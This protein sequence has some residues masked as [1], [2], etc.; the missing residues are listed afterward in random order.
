MHRFSGLL[1]LLP[2]FFDR[3]I[4]ASKTVLKMA[5]FVQIQNGGAYASVAPP[6]LAVLP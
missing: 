2:L 1:L 3:V 4:A 6:S 5:L